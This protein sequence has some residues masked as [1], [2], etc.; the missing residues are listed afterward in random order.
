MNSCDAAAGLIDVHTHVVP[1]EFPANPSP[2]TNARWP[3][4]CV[5][6]A[7]Q[8]VL[9]IDGKPFR[10]V[11]ARA[12][13][14]DARLAT[15]DR[16]GVAL[17]VLSPM[18]E[19]LS[20]WFDER[21]ALSMTHYVNA[22]LSA[23]VERAPSRFRALAMVPLQY[24]ALA[25]RELSRVKAEGFAGV[26]IGSNINGV[27]PGD[28]RFIEF[29]A[30]AERLGLA[31]FVHALHPIGAE[32]LQ[33]FPDLVPF[34]AFPLDTGLAAI[35]L[36]RAGVP[37]RLPRLRI[38]FSHGGGAIVPLVHRLHQGWSLSGGFDGA[39][40]QSP[41]HYA[42]HFYYDSLVYDAG[43]LRYLLAEFAPGQGFV[44]TDY[45]FAIEQT[46]PAGFVRTVGTADA[47]SLIC[48]AAARFLGEA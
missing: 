30:E 31:I 43:Y 36:I 12:W 14:V 45:P 35:S 42:A 28:A 40:P 48:G 34:A 44:G 4:M 20:Y 21:D 15:M 1:A 47:S 22:T 37:E 18:P 46:D 24:P 5:Q 9:T 8:R 10:A 6:A 41:H 23:M 29:Y 26:E 32:R 25:T 16:D 13:E 27:V 33:A 7:G 3:C 39:L 2:A 38:G 19:L 17:Q 11:D